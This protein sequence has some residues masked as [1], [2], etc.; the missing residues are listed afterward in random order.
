MTVDY[1]STLNLPKTDFQMKANLSKREPEIL[2]EW[3]EKGL[4]RRIKEAGR[5]R[6]RYTL[7][8]GPPYANGNIHIGH[9]LNKILK[10]IIIKSRFMMGYGTDY[11]PGWD[12]H[13]LPIEIQVEKSLAG[14]KGGHS[15]LEIRKRCREYAARFVDVQREEFKRLG[16]FGEWDNP[17]LTMNYGYQASILRE[18]AKC[19]EQGLVYKSKKPVHWC[20]SCRTALA[21]AEVEYADK[22]S[23]AVFV[24]FPVVEPH[25]A[26]TV[27][28]EKG[29]AFVIWTTTPWTLPANM[30]IALHPD[31]I[32]RLVKTPVGDLILNRELIPSCMEKFGFNEGEYE[33]AA[34]EWTGSALDRGILCRHPWIDRQVRVVMGEHVTNEAGT[35][36]VHIAPGHGQDDY[37]LGLRYDLPIHAPVDNHGRFTNEV[38]GFAGE[39]VFK[40]NE[41]I[42]DLL[43][44][45]GALIFREDMSHS[46]PHCWR[47]KRPIIFR[48]TEQWFISMK[49]ADLRKRAIAEINQVQWIPSWGRERIVNMVENRPDWCISRQR[50]WGVPI[51]AFACIS[52]CTPLLDSEI[53]DRVVDEVESEG[54]DIWFERSVGDLLPDGTTCTR[55]GGSEFS[56]EEDILDVWFDSGASFAAVLEKSDNLSFPAD[57]YL[58]GS[59]QHRGWFQSSLLV[60]V[61]TRGRA[62]FRAVLTH[63]FVVDG[64]GKK[65]SKSTG[66]VIAPQEVIERYGAEVL[67]L[68]VASEEYREDVRI[69]EEILTRLSEGYRRIRNTCR[70]IL[71]NLY[72]FTPADDI[73]PHTELLELDQL[74]LH[75]LTRLEEKVLK[76]YRE[77]EFH[78]VY[79]T[80]HQFCAV[81][82]SAFYLDIVKDRLYCSGA[83]S[84]ERR[85]AQT[86]IHHLLD[87]LVR[88]LAPIL[89]FTMD[90][91]WGFLPKG[92]EEAPSSVHLALLPEANTEWIDDEL[93]ERWERLLRVKGEIARALESARRNRIIGHSLDAR[94]TVSPPEGLGALLE[95]ERANLRDLLIVSQLDV[96]T[97]AP[98]QVEGGEYL[99]SDDIPGLKM[100][101][102][103]ARGKKCERCWNYSES[104]G[105]DSGHPTVCERCR[106]VLG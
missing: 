104:V 1:K 5:G 26:F 7:H 54:A 10:D 68:W 30:A 66:N 47:C 59:D 4:Y 62:P 46:Y 75:R 3:E 97:T 18:F 102:E 85:A 95:E 63:G 14:K 35:G 83:V 58:E 105:A 33:V 96:A 13:G 70:Y 55:C 6:E 94:V 41:G 40:A 19:V 43:E 101:V 79:H 11:V 34:E 15:K 42:I 87:H 51:V 45:K 21:E 74:I 100:V 103:K 17:Y 81:D 64:E 29:A 39:F 72:D 71:G 8:D 2:K 25:G 76:G 65:M 49:S 67:R 12:C 9:A 60:S 38:E 88:L 69:S 86:T 91:A 32:Y 77:F 106:N 37:E 56:R 16:V 52:C 24:R 93:D 50:A 22:R 20:A 48:A 99:E 90:E 73:L 44:K 89:P 98:P 80:V 61:G 82:L 27:N 36:C 31:L 78:L 23:P 53:I 28:R 92:G 84:R 57:L